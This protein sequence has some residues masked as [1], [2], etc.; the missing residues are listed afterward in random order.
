MNSMNWLRKV[1]IGFR[2]VLGKEKL[3][4]GMDNEMRSHIKMQTQE[5]IE[6][7][8]NA[9]EARYAALRQFGWVESV[10]ET[11]RDQ[12]GVSWFE[13]LGQ[14]VRYGARMLRKN[15]GFTPV[16]VL[17]LALGIGA[18]TA[19]FSI[20]YGVLFRP[21]PYR[22]PDQLVT[23]CESNLKRGIPQVVVAPGN[24]RD[25]REQNSSFVELGGQIYTSLT[26]TGLEKPEHLHAAWTTPNYFSVF[27][28]PPLLGRTFV[29]SDDP[30][31]HRVVVLS[32]GLWRR[33]FG[34]DHNVIGR[35]ITLSGLPYTVVGVMPREFKV[36]QPAAVFGLPTG[37]VQPQLWAPYPGSMSE[38]AAKCFLAFAR[39]RP[40]ITAAQAQSELNAIAE[41]A[42]Q[43]FASLKDMGATVRPLNEQIVAGS[44]PALRLLLGAVSFVLLIACANVANLLLARSTVRSREF[45]IR[46]ALGAGRGRLLCQLLIESAI[47]AVLAGGLGVL[48]AYGGL[49]SLAVL[50]PAN[51]PR[52]DEVRLDGLVLTFTMLVSLLTGVLFGLAPAL[53]ASKPDLNAALK[54]NGGR[55]GG[56]NRQQARNVLVVA[57]VALAIIL[58]TGAGLMI[59]SFARLSRVDPGFRP[60]QLVAF[61]ASPAGPA[62]A[63]DAKRRN[64]VKQLR[65]QLQAQP[66]VKSAATVYGLP[67]G[68]ML[69]SL[70]GVILENGPAPNDAR[71]SIRAGWRVV[72]P[73]YFET[74]GA[75]LIA[76]RTF[77][78]EL[79]EVKGVPV[80]II[81]ETFQRK[82]FPNDNPLGKRIKPITVSTNWHEIVGIVK[83]V[84]MTGLD[85]LAVPEIYQSD[86]QQAPWMF[87]L[88]VRSSV[89]VRQVEKMA[90]AEAAALDKDLPLFNVRTMEHAIGTSVAPQRFTM[91]LIGLFAALA[92]VLTAVG[93]YGLVSYTVTQ[94]TRA[95]GIRMALGA[96]RSDV[97]GLVIRQGVKLTLIGAALGMLGTLGLTRWLTAL[98]Y[99]IKPTNPLTLLA[100]P[101]LLIGVALL[102][103][104]APA[105]RASKI[106][107]MEALRFE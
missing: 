80:M 7:R 26:L 75:S 12:R 25:W 58:L 90:R 2:A 21:L 88:V 6:A 37:N 27:G 94:Q 60:E 104:W 66:G 19:I 53:H 106:H 48:L 67:F 69:N 42:K 85:A 41:R 78:E 93:I 4:A 64:L 72:S 30:P 59:I 81:N 84:K 11:C 105:R 29:A 57:E 14:D 91:M 15:P 32:Y 56:R 3:D 71:E 23:V 34:A 74:I 107:P 5:N 63:E 65:D 17:T 39:L 54:D 99:E 100:P 68:T 45:A 79:D 28:V 9:E 83:D 10:K 44:R 24:L 76:G 20:I 47:L 50:Q 96:Q 16:A 98:L 86:S 82:F 89:P 97:L 70:V 35:S 36:Y 62:Y 46:S 101:L 31:G 61:D 43:E 52:L 103:C 87:S 95:I 92:L 102:A 73:N 18:N 51:L 1:Q 22:N 49:A 33:S 13:N 55:D 40:D 8:M 77:S 38:R